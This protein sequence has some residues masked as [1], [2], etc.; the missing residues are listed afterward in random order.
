MSVIENLQV[1]KYRGVSFLVSSETKTGG[2][3]FV[4]HEYPNSSKRFTE[5]LGTLEPKFTIMAIV[6]GDQA[7][8]SRGLLET[9]LNEEGIGTLVHPVYGTFNNVK[10]T[11]YSVS[12]SQTNIGEFRFS[13]NFEISEEN[14]T[15]EP[16][17]QT[18][19]SLSAMSGDVRSDLDDSLGNNYDDPGDALGFSSASTALN[20]VFTKVFDKVSGISGLDSEGL[21]NLTRTVSGLKARVG[22]II[23]TATD[24]KSSLIEFWDAV[25]GVADIPEMLISAWDELI[26][27]ETDDP[28]PRAAQKA[29]QSPIFVKTQEQQPIDTTTVSRFER[30]TNRSIINEHTRLTVLVNYYEA[31]AYK[32][33]QTESDLDDVRAILAEKFISLMDKNDSVNTLVKEGVAVNEVNS[34]T[35]TSAVINSMNDLRVNATKIFEQK[36]QTLWRVVEID[37]KRSSM[38]LTSYMYYGDIDLIDIITELNPDINSANFDKEIQAVSL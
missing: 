7:I 23:L 31:A 13:I 8:Q 14:V 20:N 28:D 18:S 4:S 1:A 16:K 38:L 29:A 34:I 2:K 22:Q 19:S 5:E 26:N 11:N 12:S 37:P 32:D 3:K 24:V 6:H 33:Y 21:A 36:E 25:I 30:E 15:A 27:F 10:C 17:N 9:K 35:E